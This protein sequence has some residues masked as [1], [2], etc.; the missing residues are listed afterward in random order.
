MRRKRSCGNSV[1]SIMAAV[2]GQQEVGATDG[3]MP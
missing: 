3:E 1:M 2:D